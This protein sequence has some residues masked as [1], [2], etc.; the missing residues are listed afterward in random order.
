MALI[1][2]EAAIDLIVSQ[3]PEPHYPSWYAE[4]IRQMPAVPPKVVAEIKIDGEALQKAVDNAVRQVKRE[5]FT[6]RLNPGTLRVV[7]CKDCRFRDKPHMSSAWIP[8]VDMKV[9]NDF[10]CARGEWE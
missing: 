1:D 4:Q 9:P 2:K 8:C 5:L 3:P 7:R 10:Y 6:G